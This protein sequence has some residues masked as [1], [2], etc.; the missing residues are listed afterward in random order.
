MSSAGTE[1]IA[2]IATPPGRGGVGIVRISGSRALEIAQAV[3]SR[4]P[5]PR[6]IGFACFHSADGSLIDQGIVLRFAAPASFTGEDV[7]ELQGHGGSVV[8]DLLL[9]SVVAAGARLARPGEFS[10]RAFLNDKLDLAQAE[11]VADLIDSQTSAAARLAVRSLDG[12]FSRRVHDLVDRLT[13]LRMFVEAAID[14]PEEEIDFLTNSHVASDLVQVGAAVQLVLAAAQVGQVFRDG[15][16]VVIAGPPNA[17]KSSLLNALAGADTAIV[18]DI[19]GTTRDVL[20]E[21]VQIDG[22]PLHLIDTAGLRP[23]DD[24]I[25]QIGVARARAEIARADLI[26]WIYDGF[27][28]PT[29]QSYDVTSLP[30]TIPVSVIHNKADLSGAPSGSHPTS[31]GTELVMSTR[32]ADDLA[33]LRRHLRKTMGLDGSTEGLFIARRRHIDALRRA[34]T[35]I[36]CGSDALRQGAAGELLAE[37]LRLAQQALGEITGEFVADDLLGRIFSTFCIGK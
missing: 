12:E 15:M 22:M 18:S 9:T 26:L 2:A 31:T 14:F 13:R 16:R 29:N 11:A 34:A 24:K 28:D 23:T 36:A 5:E 37:D 10:E 32:S 35:F 19:P 21:H 30:A 17:G 1:T 8:M 6:Q 3:C 7:I 27:K 20:H 4:L 25:E 33:M